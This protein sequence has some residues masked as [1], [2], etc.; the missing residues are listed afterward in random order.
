MVAGDA[1]QADSQADATQVDAAVASWVPCGQRATSNGAKLCDDFDDPAAALGAKWLGSPRTTNGHLTTAPSTRSTPNAFAASVDTS[2]AE[3]F[4]TLRHTIGAVS[5]TAMRFRFAM[6][7]ETVGAGT[8]NLFFAVV[9]F[10]D[11]ACATQ[12]SNGSKARRVVVGIS[13]TSG[14]LVMSVAGFAA[15]CSDAGS[16]YYSRESTIDFVAA[17]AAAERWLTIR[18]SRLSCGPT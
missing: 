12:A 11:A 1:A 5:G 18:R 9:Y 17:G 7:P 4:A 15:E 8:G 2:S 16:D 6:R 10:D 3:A 13:P 14:K